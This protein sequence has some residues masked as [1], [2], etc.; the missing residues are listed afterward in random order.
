MTK[1]QT[2]EI[3]TAHTRVVAIVDR[4]FDHVA[5]NQHRGKSPCHCCSSCASH[6]GYFV[7]TDKMIAKAE[8][9]AIPIM[10]NDKTGFLGVNGCTI[11]LR[12]DRSLTCILYVCHGSLPTY[13]RELLINL[14]AAIEGVVGGAHSSRL[15]VLTNRIAEFMDFVCDRDKYKKQ[16]EKPRA[17]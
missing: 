14:R 3:V 4:L 16:L 17:V 1:E 6:K 15:D 7:I 9:R 13:I 5:I 11:R 2:K 10:P 12:R 8:G